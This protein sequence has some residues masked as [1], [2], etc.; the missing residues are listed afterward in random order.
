MAVRWLLAIVAASACSSDE[1]VEVGPDAGEAVDAAIE[2][3][4]DVPA[5][6]IDIDDASEVVIATATGA[7]EYALSVTAKSMSA[8]QWDEANNEALVLEISGAKRGL[9][10]HLVMHQ[11]R[12]S[13]VYTMHAGA[14]AANEA[15]RARVSTLSA[16]NAVRAAC[17][18]V[19][20]LTPASAMGAA[21]AGMLHA[22]EFR[23][24]VQKRF[25]DLPVV[26][27]WSKARESYQTVFTNE[28]G[29]TVEQ[30]GGGA[31]GVR[32]EIARWGRA[33]DIEGSYSYGGAAPRWERCTGSVPTTT[34]AVRMEGDHPR[35]YYGDGHNRL[36]ESRGGYG[37]TCG[38]GGPEK[39]NGDLAGWN[40]SNPGNQL[41]NDDGRVIILRPLPVDMD[42]LGFAQFGDRRE[43]LAD[44]YAPWVYRLTT[45]ELRREGKIDND[46]TLAMSRY[47]YV[48]IRVA[49]VGGS[50]DQYCA[51]LGVGSGFKLRAVT[52]ND[53]TIDGPQ[54]TADYASNGAHDYKR[55]AIPLPANVTAA[56]IDH[57]VFDAYD[58]D[59]IYVT[60]IGDAFIPVPDGPNGATLAYVRMG[61]RPYAYYVDDNSDGCT[62]GA[63]TDGP[64]G[65]PYQ[66]KGGQV[67]I[68]K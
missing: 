56:N 48:D 15:I 63:N 14:L 60:A 2:V 51:F 16:T 33:S 6:C 35:L 23:W 10:G 58:D 27:G 3:D 66:C 44:R 8:T 40:T 39:A 45:H 31:E 50:G 13:F 36:F 37:Q 5:T 65:G 11:G 25:N 59:G 54:I 7:D 64:G 49:D 28:D 68:P 67:S 57:F 47:L 32:A 41:A 1:A 19:A 38:S 46:Q 24:P 42:A 52:T 61:E 20:T 9:I 62:N 30:C 18:T 12:T 34:T 53:V 55:V 26:V 22:P 21:A 4:A 29:G 17:V 43:A